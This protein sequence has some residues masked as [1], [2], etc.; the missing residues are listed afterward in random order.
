MKVTLI[1]HTPNPQWLIETCARISYDSKNEPFDQK[2]NSEFIRKLVRNGHESPL[3]HASATFLIEGVSRACSHQI[4]RHR[5]ASFSQRSDRYTRF[6]TQ[7][8]GHAP[9]MVMPVAFHDTIKDMAELRDD[10]KNDPS[11]FRK[12]R[13][14][15]DSCVR[16]YEDM[17]DAGVPKEDARL[18]LPQ[19]ISTSLYMTANFRE[20][21][22]FLQL[23]LDKHAQWEI[24]AVAREILRHLC[25]DGMYDCFADIQAEF[26]C[27]EAQPRASGIT[28]GRSDKVSPDRVNVLFK[29]DFPRKAERILRDVIGADVS[30]SCTDN[31]FLKSYEVSNG[32]DGVIRFAMD[33]FYFYGFDTENDLF[34]FWFYR[35]K[36]LMSI[37]NGDGSDPEA[38]K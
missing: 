23:R 30:I 6:S 8:I 19:G 32:S 31:G 27:E 38:A 36:G 37:K 20:W 3:E 34:K 4:V 18:I 5:L 33:P 28:P 21:R 17:L 25:V 14:A 1:S 15:F 10:T 35:F 7:D 24:R 9:S 16:A 29:N 2:V 13:D 12:F 11:L 26:D 22:H